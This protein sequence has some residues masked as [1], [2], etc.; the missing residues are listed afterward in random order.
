MSV[1]SLILLQLVNFSIPQFPKRFGDGVKF[2]PQEAV[3]QFAEKKVKVK[4]SVIPEDSLEAIVSRL[5]PHK[6][7]SEQSDDVAQRIPLG[8]KR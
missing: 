4:V 3:R 5:A 8:R 7:I 2:V 6:C 1:A